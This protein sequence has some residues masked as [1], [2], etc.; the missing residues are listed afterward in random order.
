MKKKKSNIFYCLGKKNEIHI[1]FKHEYDIL[2]KNQ[3][4][5]RIIHI[6]TNYL[7]TEKEKIIVQ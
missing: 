5:C 3:C 2:A 1:N 6:L 4:S 7:R